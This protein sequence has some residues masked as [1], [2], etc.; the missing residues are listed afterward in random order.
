[1]KAIRPVFIETVAQNYHDLDM[2]LGQEEY[3]TLPTTAIRRNDGGGDYFVT[4]SRWA[5]TD[6]ERK[7]IEHG[8][9][10]V[11]QVIHTI[12]AYPP[13]NLQVVDADLDPVVVR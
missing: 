1:M 7:S 3:S 12:G 2:G 4:V 8:A 13:M 10:I 5:L 9:D 6:D 11:H